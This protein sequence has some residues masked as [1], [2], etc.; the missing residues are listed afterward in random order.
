MK[1]SPWVSATSRM[2]LDDDGNC[3]KNSP[4]IFATSRMKIGDDDDDKDWGQFI[5]ICTINI[6]ISDIAGM[7]FKSHRFASVSDYAKLII[8][9]EVIF[10]DFIDYIGVH[11]TNFLM[12]F[13]NRIQPKDK[14]W[15]QMCH[16]IRPCLKFFSII[17]LWL[18]C[19]EIHQLWSISTLPLQEFWWIPC[20]RRQEKV[21]WIL[22][23]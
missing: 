15:K 8:A 1:I 5:Y 6:N 2:K 9:D 11:Y 23:L 3:M 17:R 22:A 14:R 18:P 21:W 7:F 19:S 16:K 20:H 4:R 10:L 13:P 12:K